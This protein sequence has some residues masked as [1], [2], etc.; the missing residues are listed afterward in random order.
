[1]H[2]KV[3]NALD[4]PF[5]LVRDKRNSNIRFNRIIKNEEFDKKFHLIG[6]A[7]KLMIIIF[8]RI[9]TLLN[10]NEK[11][12]FMRYSLFTIGPDMEDQ[13]Q[14]NLISQILVELIRMKTFVY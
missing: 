12:P 3:L 2:L 1:M 7:T 13:Q 6:M 9:I 4:A 5:K 11:T 10:I 14:R 8:T